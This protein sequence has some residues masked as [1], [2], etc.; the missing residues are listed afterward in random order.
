MKKTLRHTLRKSREG[1]VAATIVAALILAMA[2]MVPA[3]QEAKTIVK[4]GYAPVNGLNLYYEV[5]GGGKPVILLHGGLESSE[6]LG[7]ALTEL[8]KTRQVVTADLQAHGHTADINRPLSAE[9]MADD[10][11]GLMKHLEIQKADVMGC[12]LGAGVALQLTIR[13]PQLVRKLVVVSEPCKREGW[14]PEVLAI[15]AQM[16]PA[17]AEPMKQS[18]NYKVYAHSAPRPDDWPVLLSKVGEFLRRN[19]DWSSKVAAIKVPTMLVFADADAMRPEHMVEFFQLL[20]GGKKDG[21]LDGS[22]I[23]NA[24]LAILP[25]LTHY[26]IFSSSALVPAVTP[27]LDAPLPKGE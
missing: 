26:N 21:G 16:G 24:R 9:A 6:I 10:I 13:H 25:G 11:A 2:S 8:E 23:S 12:S 18:H 19:Y 27:F 20:G 7:V 1:C 14:Y 15:M 4:T 3:Q 22:G 5:H 17:F